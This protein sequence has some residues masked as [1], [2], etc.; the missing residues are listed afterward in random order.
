MMIRNNAIEH[1][2][3]RM[4][5]EGGVINSIY[6]ATGDMRY[7]RVYFRD[8][9]DEMFAEYPP[10]FVLSVCNGKDFDIENAYFTMD[11]NARMHSYDYDGIRQLMARW[12]NHVIAYLQMKMH[13]ETDIPELNAM[14][15]SADSAMFDVDRFYRQV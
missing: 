10:T 7:L 3:R 1:F 6:D 5:K 2:V 12:N 8:E 9:L 13:I 4:N 15:N 11:R 14:V